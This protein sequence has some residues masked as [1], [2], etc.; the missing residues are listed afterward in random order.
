MS[1]EI[2][3]LRHGETLWNVE[4]RFQGRLDSPLTARGVQQAERCGRKLAATLGQVDAMV[5]SPLGRV[6]QTAAIIRSLGGYPEI[7]WDSRLAEVSFGGWDGL[8]EAEIDAGWPGLRDGATRFDWY[9]RSP[10]GETLDSAVA[11]VRDWLGE[12][13]GTVVAISH[14]LLGRIIRGAYLGLAEEE[15]L[16]LPVS[17]EV[18]WR[19]AN[20][21]V[22]A[23]AV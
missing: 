21:Q 7:R 19:M 2:Y 12:L 17:H 13:E 23:I 14:G 4:G 10:D 9:F 11:R 18:I 5:A 20:R 8:T 16:R 1:A 3:L 22:D 6:R 15:A